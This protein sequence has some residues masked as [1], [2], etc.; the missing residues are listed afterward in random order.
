MTLERLMKVFGQDVAQ[1][2]AEKIVGRYVFI[3]NLSQGGI[4]RCKTRVEKLKT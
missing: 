4:G 2:L 1:L 3:V